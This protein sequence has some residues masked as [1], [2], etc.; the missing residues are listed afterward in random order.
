M[1]YIQIHVLC[2]THKVV[3]ISTLSR[4]DHGIPQTREVACTKEV[5]RLHEV[6]HVN[7]GLQNAIHKFLVGLNVT[8]VAHDIQQ[9][10]SRFI[11]ADLSLVNSYDTWHGTAHVHIYTCTMYMYT[12]MYQYMYMLYRYKECV[13]ADA[14]H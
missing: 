3:G 10:V 7:R 5:L 12:C 1:H 9:Q 6:R 11:T 2:S 4:A 8:E 14:E 13:E